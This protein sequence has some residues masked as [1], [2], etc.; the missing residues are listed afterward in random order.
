MN[1]IEWVK[2]CFVIASELEKLV[3][4]LTQMEKEGEKREEEGF[5]DICTG[6][7]Q[8]AKRNMHSEKDALLEAINLKNPRKVFCSLCSIQGT[9]KYFSDEN[10]SWSQ[11]WNGATLYHSILDKIILLIQ[12]EKVGLHK[13]EFA[14]ALLTYDPLEK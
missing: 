5:Q 1:A 14:E 9:Y 8:V 4:L 7:L 12:Y 13:K 3:N 11:L 2:E 6:F 10:L